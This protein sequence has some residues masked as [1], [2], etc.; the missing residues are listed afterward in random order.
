MV[1]VLLTRGLRRSRKSSKYLESWRTPFILTP[2]S[3]ACFPPRWFGFMTLPSLDILR[4]WN[5][6]KLFI[7]RFSCHISDFFALSMSYFQWDLQEKDRR[8]WLAMTKMPSILNFW[9]ISF[10]NV[11]LRRELL[12]YGENGSKSEPFPDLENLSCAIKTSAEM[13]STSD[14]IKRNQFNFV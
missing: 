14:L 6:L 1:P 3:L 10:D 5:A 11:K 2:T 12:N 13:E 8:I 7:S 9:N 4:W